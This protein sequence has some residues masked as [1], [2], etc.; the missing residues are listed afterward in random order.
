MLHS[1]REE[2]TRRKDALRR[3]PIL[4]TALVSRPSTLVWVSGQAGRRLCDEHLRDLPG[5]AASRSPL[6]ADG[7]RLP[8]P[9]DLAHRF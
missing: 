5:V 1:V 6:D 7:H 2:R 9:F 3:T 8:T 4:R